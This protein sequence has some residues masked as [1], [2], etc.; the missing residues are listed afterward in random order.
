MRECF[1][2]EKHNQLY[3]ALP[4]PRCSGL[5][6]WKSTGRG[7]STGSRGASTA[8][9]SPP[10]LLLFFI[11]FVCQSSVRSK[12]GG[13]GKQVHTILFRVRSTREAC[14]FTEERI[15]TRHM[16]RLSVAVPSGAK[17]MM[18]QSRL[19][20]IQR[21]K[22][23]TSQTNWLMTLDALCNRLLLWGC[24]SR[25]IIHHNWSRPR[26]YSKCST[27]DTRK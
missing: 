8:G 25:L 16:L 19:S 27:R 3:I 21:A 2:W 17:D 14:V 22:T 7:P 13:P 10:G 26:V 11:I 24:Y 18:L 4:G 20:A 23:N 6:Q 15:Q 1:Q 5:S 9:P 12:G